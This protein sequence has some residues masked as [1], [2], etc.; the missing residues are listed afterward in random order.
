MLGH[1][2]FNNL[3]KMRK[4]KLVDG[5]PSKLEPETMKCGTCIR[6]EMH[7][8]PFIVCNDMLFYRISG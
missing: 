4:N 8:S 3:E 6:N 5:M 1:I 7:H 2:H